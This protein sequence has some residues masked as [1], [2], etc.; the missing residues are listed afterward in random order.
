MSQEQKH[1]TDSFE[2]IEETLGRG[3]QFVEKNQKIITMVALAIIVVIGGHFGFKKFITEPNNLEAEGQ[4]FKAQNYFA[5]DSFELAL[6]GDGNNLGFIDVIDSYGS[7]PSGNLA[8]YYA[9]VCCLYLGQNE[10]AINYLKNFSS[11]DLL[12]ANMAIA[13]IGDAYMQLKNYKEAASNYAKAVNS[14][15]NTFSTPMFLQKQGLAEELSGNYTAAIAVYNKI[16][17]E[18]PNSVE[19]RDVEKYIERAEIEARK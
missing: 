16:K 10:E 14:K 1:S 15:E 11:D 5:L 12:M 17:T 4:I 18:Y 6:N 3:E 13:N 19:A 2:Q 9:G 7:T 8:N